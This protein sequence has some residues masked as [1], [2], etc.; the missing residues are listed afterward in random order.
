MVFRNVWF[1]ETT[2]K[3]TNLHAYMNSK[4]L[5]EFFLHNVL[6]LAVS[7]LSECLVEIKL[8]YFWKLSC[9]TWYFTQTTQERDVLFLTVEKKKNTSTLLM[10]I[11]CYFLNPFHNVIKF[12]AFNRASFSPDFHIPKFQ[13]NIYIWIH[14]C[15]RS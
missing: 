2:S 4:I 3:Q 12:K 11:S 5:L 7:D 14:L 13:L 8:L 9:G 1:G 15:M 6:L 10:R